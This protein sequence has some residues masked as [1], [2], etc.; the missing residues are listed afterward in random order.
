VSDQPIE[1]HGAIGDLHAQARA[2]THLALVSAA[3]DLD[4][5]AVDGRP[6]GVRAGERSGNGS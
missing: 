2:F 4:P 5:A 6:L 1:T 3:H